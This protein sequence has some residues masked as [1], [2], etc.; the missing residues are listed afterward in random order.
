VNF[1]VPTPPGGLCSRLRFPASPGRRDNGASLGK[2]ALTMNM[3]SGG[4]RKYCLPLFHPRNV[5]VP[6]SVL[7][8]LFVAVFCVAH[9]GVAE[10]VHHVVVARAGGSFASHAASSGVGLA[11]MAGAACVVA[12][13][14]RGGLSVGELAEV[15]VGLQVFGDLQQVQDVLFAHGFTR[16]RS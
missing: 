4:E 13:C 11:E 2:S 16:V 7:Q 12:G 15:R 1:N 3:V 14:G 8:D 6:W 10:A 9:A 5:E